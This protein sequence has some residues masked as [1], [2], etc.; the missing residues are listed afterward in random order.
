MSWN[1]SEFASIGDVTV[2][3]LRYYDKINLL[4]PSDYTE[5][6]HR[7][8]V[9]DD[10][11]ILQQIQALKHFGFP[12]GEIQNIIFQNDIP[13]ENFMELIH[14]Q[15]ELLLVEQERI[16]KVLKHMDEMVEVVQKEERID[17]PLFC[18]ILQTFIWEKENREWLEERGIQDIHNKELKLNFNQQFMSLIKQ[19]KRYREEKKDP[20]HTD[21]QAVVKELYYLIEEIIQSAGIPQADFRN[22]TKQGDIPLTEFP[23]LLTREEERYLK[24]AMKNM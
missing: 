24:E 18:S 2:R 19:I 9:K 10:L 3:T 8:Y 13:K 20:A 11:Y 7:L 5:G 16:A 1:I 22:I 4:K 21:V 12:L 23:A 14:F 17:V 15:R 6:G